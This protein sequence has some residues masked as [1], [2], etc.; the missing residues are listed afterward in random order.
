MGYLVKAS[1]S[2]EPR[3]YTLEGIR[4]DVD[5]GLLPPTA[6]SRHEKQD[7]WYSVAELIGQEPTP[8]F[9]FRCKHCRSRLAARKMDLGLQLQC[10]KCKKVSDVP[11]IGRAGR[12]MMVAG[13]IA[14]CLGLITAVA[15]YFMPMPGSGRF[16]FGFIGLFIIGTLQS[17]QGWRLSTQFC[18]KAHQDRN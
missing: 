2:A 9:R 3:A 17:F 6:M 15:N 8:T 10:E 11:D 12:F 4:A 14:A 18:T 7:F 13:A 1:F 5:A 16:H